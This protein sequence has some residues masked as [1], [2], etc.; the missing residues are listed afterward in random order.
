MQVLHQHKLTTAEYFS[1]GELH[2]KTELINGVIYD[3]VPPGPNH[4]YV[5][6]EIAK[7]LILNLKDEVI[8]QEQPLQ[9]LPDN[10]PQP[11]IVILKP[12]ENGYKNAHPK[13][14]DAMVIIEVSDSTLGYDTGDKMTMYATANVALYFIVDLNNK[15]ILKHTDPGKKGYKSIQKCQEIQI[16]SLSIMITLNDIL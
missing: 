5:V 4:S 12:S 2:N 7:S 1:I 3:K 9:F 13:S 10:A 8:R 14:Q 16:D 6:G 11:D 15:L